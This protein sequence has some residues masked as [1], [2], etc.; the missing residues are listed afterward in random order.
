MPLPGTYAQPTYVE[1]WQAVADAAGAANG[2][3]PPPSSVD[4]LPTP[5]RGGLLSSLS[6]GEA[7]ALVQA[8][9]RAAARSRYA[10]PWVEL[11]AELLGSRGPGERFD[12]SAAHRNARAP[13]DLLLYLWRSTADLARSLDAS[14]AVVRP[15][16]PAFTNATYEQAA[17]DAWE[18]AKAGTSDVPPWL[19]PPRP[20]N[21][22]PA[23]PLPPVPPEIPRPGDDEWD[24][25]VDPTKPIRKAGSMLLV[26]V[27]ALAALIIYTRR[28]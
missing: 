24:V 27:A 16:A 19:L 18:A 3:R 22:D 12:M 21:Q 20:P 17:R 10:W 26:G 7:V 14:G 8:W 28:R 2:L 9:R 25:I 5:L 13:D 6:N 1:Q 15:L 4:E 11:T 23:T